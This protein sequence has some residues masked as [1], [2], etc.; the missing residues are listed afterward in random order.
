MDKETREKFTQL[1]IEKGV[2]Q[3]ISKWIRTICITSTVSVWGFITWLGSIVYD[4][5]PA[6]KAGVIALVTAWKETK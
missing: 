1:E 4:Q 2:Q 6:F 3:G 5:F